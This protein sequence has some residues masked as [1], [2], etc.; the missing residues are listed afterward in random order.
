MK[1]AQIIWQVRNGI[2]YGNGVTACGSRFHLMIERD[3]A[4][5]VH[6]DL[7]LGVNAILV[8]DYRIEE[9][10]IRDLIF[11]EIL[12]EKTDI[13]FYGERFEESVV[14]SGERIENYF[15]HAYENMLR[16]A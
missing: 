14:Y 7:T 10:E 3:S 11:G 6:V 9:S 2:M 8:K 15:T 13:I 12:T 5:E 1:K 4:T 16:K